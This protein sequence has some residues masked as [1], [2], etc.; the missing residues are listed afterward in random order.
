V[1]VRDFYDG[2]ASDFHLVYEDWESAVQRQSAA[3]DR[4]I[5]SL[6]P[7]ATD[8]LDCSCGI[9]TQ[10][11]GLARLGWHVCGTDISERSLERARAEAIRLGAEVSFAGADFRDLSSVAAKFDVVISCDNALPHLLTDDDLSRAFVAMRSKLR[12]S[13]LLVISVRDYDLAMVERPASAMPHI[14]PGPPRRVIV[15]L[16]DWDGPDSPMHTVRFLVLTEHA[17]GWTIDHH[18][19]RY[20]AVGRE[21]LTRIATAAGFKHISWHAAETVGFHQPVMTAFR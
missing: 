3:L 9:G 14:R 21:T 19:V 13:G 10:A 11:I 18:S 1:S 5:R 7:A 17:T 15:R 12:S 6:N 4:L 2:F 16:H 8:L 20:R